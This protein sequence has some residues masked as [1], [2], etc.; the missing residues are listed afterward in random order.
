MYYL[1][2]KDIEECTNEQKKV[3]PARMKIWL[4]EVLHILVKRIIMLFGFGLN[5]I[6]LKLV[7]TKE[8]IL[9]PNISI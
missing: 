7:R 4:D 2:K 5:F 1:L 8:K 6:C 9:M 3:F